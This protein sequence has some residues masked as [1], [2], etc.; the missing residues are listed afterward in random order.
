M[1]PSS[2]KSFDP[3]CRRAEPS[4]SSVRQ[5]G[6]DSA[7]GLW[8]SVRVREPRYSGWGRG[9]GRG[10]RPCR[11]LDK[12]SLTEG[13]ALGHGGERRDGR[14]QTRDGGVEVKMRRHEKE[15]WKVERKRETHSHSLWWG[16]V[17]S[18]SQFICGP[19]KR[20]RPVE[21]TITDK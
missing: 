11:R 7:I 10:L 2:V 4:R 8:P 6:R 12:Q 16:M 19:G 17:T 5:L 1:A 20:I 9:G 15:E 21:E 13:R 14:M 3:F 18:S